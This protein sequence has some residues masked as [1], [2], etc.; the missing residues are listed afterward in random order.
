MIETTTTIC[1]KMTKKILI[2]LQV[3][4]VFYTFSNSVKGSDDVCTRSHQGCIRAC[5]N[6]KENYYMAQC[7]GACGT[8]LI[9]CR[10]PEAKPA[11]MAGFIIGR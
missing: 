5:H 6:I 10:G 1:E 2:S 4:L 7:H 3:A 9:E 11:K 8:G